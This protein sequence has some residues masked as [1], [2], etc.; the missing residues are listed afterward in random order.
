MNILIQTPTFIIRLF[1]PE[2]EEIYLNL[3]ND[4]RVTP[5]LPKRSREEHIKIFREALIESPAG[6]IMGRWGIF[7][8]ADNDYIGFCILR[9]FDDDSDDIEFGYALH[10]NYWGKG[11]ATEM[12]KAF[13]NHALTIQ[14]NTKFVA[15]TVIENIPS[16][17]V[18]EKA[19]M[20]RMENCVRHGEEL[21]FFRMRD[22]QV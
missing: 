9:P 7:N 1:K 11:I 22:R 13:L 5:Y 6:A 18:L 14:S 16:Q 15:V 19:G 17:R 2:E 8:K 4:D 3:F 20:L 10:Y 21:A 12:A